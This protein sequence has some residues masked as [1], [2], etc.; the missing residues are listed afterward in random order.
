[1]ILV[2]VS[3]LGLMAL[4]GT[5]TNGDAPPDQPHEIANHGVSISSQPIT[6]P[7]GTRVAALLPGGAP[8]RSVVRHDTGSG[9][10]VPAAYTELST[11]AQDRG[12]EVTIYRIFS[13]EEM[14]NLPRV[15]AASGSAWLGASYPGI[16]SIYYLSS[17][18]KV[19]LRVASLTPE[20]G[21]APAGTK[22][23]PDAP[24]TLV[25]IAEQLG[26]DPLVIEEATK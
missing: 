17:D 11:V 13:T 25:A 23:A 1:M 16:T 9:A 14:A 5:P 21:L 20:P 19:G 2:L 22:T 24:R 4:L 3:A 6:S 10:P 26:R 18:R 7:V 15:H 8:L 12:Y